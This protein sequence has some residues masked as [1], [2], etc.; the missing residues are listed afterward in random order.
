MAEAPQPAPQA[1]VAP[2]IATST[3]AEDKAF[4]YFKESTNLLDAENSGGCKGLGQDCNGQLV[5]DCPDWKTNYACQDAY[6]ERY[7]TSRYGTW[8]A[9]KAHWT[10]RVPINGQNVGNW[11]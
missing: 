4:I 10:A 1:V 7:M 11:W 6:W 3:E 2:I 8:G 9:A 5:I